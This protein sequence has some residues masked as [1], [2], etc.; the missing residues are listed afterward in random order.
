MEKIILV[1]YNDDWADE[2]SI[3]GFCIVTESV[4]KEF[5]KY[6]K[7]KSFEG[8]EMYFGTNEFIEFYYKSY[9]SSFKIQEIT[10]KEC[11]FLEKTFNIKLNDNLDDLIYNCSKFGTILFPKNKECDE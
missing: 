1:N 4:W 9:K 3:Y 11:V 8:Q 7:N 10:K 2:F 6:I 5:Q